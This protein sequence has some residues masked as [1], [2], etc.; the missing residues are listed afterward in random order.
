M[1]EEPYYKLTRYP[2]E[3][4]H[5]PFDRKPDEALAL[6]AWRGMVK[7]TG[8]SAVGEPKLVGRYDIDTD[9][10]AYYVTGQVIDRPNFE[11]KISFGARSVVIPERS[12]T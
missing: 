3:W 5:I 9:E 8:R 12:L 1:I 2:I 4:Y 11:G 7:A 6:D 10:T